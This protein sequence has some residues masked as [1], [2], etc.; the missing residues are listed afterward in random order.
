MNYGRNKFVDKMYESCEEFETMV[1]I[2]LFQFQT[3]QLFVSMVI[4]GE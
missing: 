1:C 4:I 2:E 3:L